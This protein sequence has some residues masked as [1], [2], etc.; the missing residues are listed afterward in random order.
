MVN[1]IQYGLPTS[2][3]ASVEQPDADRTPAPGRSA[4]PMI[5]SSSAF[6]QQLPDDAPAR[7]TE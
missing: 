3:V 2:V 1:W 4:P 6:D 7:R 5:E